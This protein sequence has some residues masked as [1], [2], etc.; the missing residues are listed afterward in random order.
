VL[1]TGEATAFA[2]SGNDVE[3]E[4]ERFLALTV[5]GPIIGIFPS[6]VHEQETIQMNIGVLLIAYTDG[7][8]EALRP[9]EEEFG[10]ERL[11]RIVDESADLSADR[12]SETIVESVREWCRDKPLHD[13]LTLVVMMK[14]R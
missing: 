1:S 10:E 2:A 9:D 5:G 7:V 8:P 14:V 4:L 12:I 6:C 13:D 3:P 11:Y